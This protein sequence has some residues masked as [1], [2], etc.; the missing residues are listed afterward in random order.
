[1]AKNQLGEGSGCL[2]IIVGA[3][4]FF[5]GLNSWLR[6]E[7]T[8]YHATCSSGGPVLPSTV[9]LSDAVLT[10]GFGDALAAYQRTIDSCEILP[11]ARIT[12]KLNRAR[13]EV[14]YL[15]LGSVRR[16]TNCAFVD[17]K[18]W[19]CEYRDGSGSV[20][21]LDG[22]QAYTRDELLTW[23]GQTPLFSLRRWQWWLCTLIWYGSRPSGSWLIPEQTE[24]F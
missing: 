6:D 1:M 22:L 13:G 12:Y 8:I 18:N 20:T 4:W 10:E 19:S 11:G 5:G 21:I 24:S 16:L 23:P 17:R 9:A 14:A 15:S 3:A 2:L 7:V